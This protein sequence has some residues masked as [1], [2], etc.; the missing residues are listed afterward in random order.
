MKWITYIL[1]TGLFIVQVSCTKDFTQLNTDPTRATP[2]SFNVDYFL[3]N[4]Q[5]TYKETIGG[6]D[7]PVLFQ[8]GWVQLL[9]STSTGGATYYSNM[10][11][12]VQSSNTLSYT[13]GAWNDAFRSASLANEII[14]IYGAD[15]ARA[16]SVAAATVIKVM[17]LAYA[18]DIYGDIPYTEAF[19]GAEGLNAPKYDKQQDVLKGLLAELETAT[20]LFDASKQALSVDLIYNK[21]IAKWKKLANSVMLRIAMRFTK[22][23]AAF[24]KAWAEKAYAGGVFTSFADD[25][26]MKS[27]QANGYTNPN[28]RA[29]DIPADLY[30]TRWSKTLI[31]FLKATTDPRVSAIAEIPVAGFA[32]NNSLS[33]G[34]NTYAK[35]LGMPNGYDMNAGATD[36]SKAPGYPG[37]SGGAGDVTPIGNYSRPRGHYRDRNGALFM[38]TYA[39]TELLLAEAAVRGWSVGANAATHYANGL[40]AGMM[41]MANLGTT[42]AIPEAT[43]DAYVAA[44]PLNVT[45]TAASLKMINEQ[46]WATTGILMN[47][48]EAWSN[49][50]RSGY[51]VLTPVTFTGNFSG[52]QIPRRQLYPTG[53]ASLNGTNYNAG[54]QGLTPASDNW[55]SRVWWDQ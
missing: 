51:P 5:N 3:T 34:D 48:S 12:Y 7:G 8:T 46:F 20:K 21:D 29:Y 30:E 40:K 55:S 39:E 37:P 53:E 35:Q 19:K 26:F 23:D 44:N 36:I 45:S 10:D 13:A 52:G 47:G 24:A 16:N 27:D 32:G 43:I 28:N 38:M 33:A 17:A 49:W 54:V 2:A 18:T 25:A 50:R 14:K 42:A 15:P 4:A 6:Y 41:T 31:D 11:K 1:L 22:R 9:A